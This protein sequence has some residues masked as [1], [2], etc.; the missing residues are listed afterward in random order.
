MVVLLRA[1]EA[2]RWREIADELEASGLSV[3]PTSDPAAAQRWCDEGA[4]AVLLLARGLGPDETVTLTARLC[5]RGSAPVVVWSDRGGDGLLE[6]IAVGAADYVVGPPADGELRARLLGAIENDYAIRELRRGYAAFQKLFHDAVSPMAMADPEGRFVD[7]NAAF[8]ELLGYPLTELR[9]LDVAAITHGQDAATLRLFSELAHGE[10]SA[11]RVTKRFMRQDGRTVWVNLNASR[12]SDPL[13]GEIRL[14]ADL[15]DLT[16]EVESHHALARAHNRYEALF[17]EVPVAVLVLDLERM[18]FTEVNQAAEA[19]F[20]YTRRELLALGLADL[21]AGRG[22]SPEAI[23]GLLQGEARIGPTR[24]R[25]RRA[26][27][28]TIEAELTITGFEDGGGATRMVLVRDLT[29]QLQLEG[30]LERLRRPGGQRAPP[31]PEAHA[32][33]PPPGVDR[34]TILLVDDDEA[35]LTLVAEMLERGGHRV[36]AAPGGRQALDAARRHP[37][38]VDLLVVDATLVD[39]SASE[40]A[41]RLAE[42]VPNLPVLVISGYLDDVLATRGSLGSD[43]PFLSKPFNAGELLQ[44]VAAAVAGRQA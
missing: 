37:G 29:A 44:A 31:A 10:R 16:S 42:R 3:L 28:G 17:E 27:G 32:A 7:A 5:R 18:R 13:T 33:R 19:T 15:Q 36:L 4:E 30:E 43:T 1:L 24:Q 2:D 9:R 21:W 8:L 40:L 23:R 34:L 26:D 41:E 14:I 25:L 6:L 38:G 20:G 35:V 11:Y 22:A 39:P 12:F